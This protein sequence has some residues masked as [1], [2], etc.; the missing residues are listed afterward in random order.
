[1][2]IGI[3]S[4]THDQTASLTRA[5]DL[6]RAE[7]V[8][9]LLHCGDIENADTVAA[10]AGWDVH[11]VY[12]N[13]DW[14]KS[15]LARAMDAIGATN[16]KRYGH[17]E[18]EGVTLGWTH[19]D[20]ADLLHDLIASGAYDFIFHGHTHVAGERQSGRTRI[21]NPGAFTRVSQK[22]VL[23]LDLPAGKLQWLSVR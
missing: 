5:L 18:C 21:L 12:G 22:S 11:F 16:H 23:I 7:G 6:L 3:L 13:C 1:M 8:S 20:D 15:G 4:D 14:D 10:F 9:L 19:G 2:K 17:L